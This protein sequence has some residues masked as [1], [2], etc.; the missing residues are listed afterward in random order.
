MI[1]TAVIGARGYVGAEL[2]GLLD[3]HPKVEV[4]AASSR[5]HAGKAVADIIDGFSE[6]DLN[7][8]EL[9]PADVAGLKLDVCFLA[10]PN[11]LAADF[12]AAI[13]ESSAATSIIDLSADYRFDDAWVYGQPE[14]MWAFLA[15]AKR[16]SNPGCYATGAQLGLAPLLEQLAEPPA[17]FG[18]SGYSG[19]G[20]AP[21]RNN[22]PDVLADNIIPYKL[23][24]H[25]HER[26]VSRTLAQQVRFSP[27]VASFFR[28]IHLTISGKLQEPLSAAELEDQ[29]Q[30]CYQDSPLIKISTA[31]PEVRDA[32][33]KHSV[34]IGGFTVSAEEPGHFVLVVTLDN[35]LKGAATQ[36]VQNMNLAL[37][38]EFELDEFNGI[39]YEQ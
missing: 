32:A 11:G 12:V 26:E 33:C 20:T 14:R 25:I 15:G 1:R 23:T 5:A 29:F 9:N 30:N 17:V 10:L 27:H 7:F 6:K 34:Q 38:L 35:L 39:N 8:T 3:H 16:I 4:V 22:D 28:G 36:A 2:L 24:E 21:S 18:I 13:D 31:A 19:A 37:A